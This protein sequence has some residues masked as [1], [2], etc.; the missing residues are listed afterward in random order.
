MITPAALREISQL[1]HQAEQILAQRSVSR[2][3]QKRADLLLSKIG[4]IRQ[5]GY[6]SNEQRQ[7]LANEI[8]R[9]IGLPTVQFNTE[10]P[11]QRAHEQLFRRF[12]TGDADSALET[13]QRSSTL[14]TAGQQTP[15]FT[16]GP[17][18][19]VLVPIKFAQQVAEAR[20]AI[21]P[22]FNPDLVTLVQEDNFTLPPMSV[23]GWDLS[24]IAA[25][26]TGEAVQ[27]NPDVIPNI[28]T[29]MTNKFTYRCTLS[30]T[31][32][33][34]Q[35]SNA[36]GSTEAALAR[37]FGVAFGRGVSADLIN[38]DGSTGPQGALFGAQNSGITTAAAGVIGLADINGIYFS[39]NA[40]YRNSPKCAWVMNDA[41]W[42]LCCS[43]VDNSGR[44]LLPIDEDAMTLKGKPV[45]I[46]PSMP[47][48]AGSKAVL[49][50]DFANY[51][52]HSSTLFIRRRTQYPGLVEY[53]ITA[54]TGLQMVDA[55]V[56]DPT[57][58]A[59]SGQYSPL[60]Y[61]TLHS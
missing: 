46:S 52:V 57:D 4:S 55:A 49:F 39:V 51:F 15:I 24:S 3:D 1:Q 13:E 42:K 12:L 17:E 7:L 11:E 32:E 47:S 61:A 56:F 6:S 22:L 26:K 16:S 45:Y 29:R 28:D 5:A 31:M 9:E 37:A 34:E 20:A 25:T 44:P 53:G 59:N 36:Y 60:K 14:L 58:G 38:G 10:T 54:W 33:F 18:G 8:N 43:A 21:D 2:T 41:T 30:G 19:G 23:P 27:H 50:G 48:G 40:A 35:D